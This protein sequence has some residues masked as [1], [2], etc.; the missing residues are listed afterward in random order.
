MSLKNITPEA[1]W[2]ID[3]DED[4][5][6]GYGCYIHSDYTRSGCDLYNCGSTISTYLVELDG[7]E[8]SI[9]NWHYYSLKENN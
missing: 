3:C 7:K 5:C 2:L 8:L 9:C 4:M 6:D 1:N